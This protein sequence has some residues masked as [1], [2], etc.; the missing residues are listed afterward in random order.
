MRPLGMK[1][2]E[3]WEFAGM[4]T[5]VRAY[6]TNARRFLRGWSY[7]EVYGSSEDR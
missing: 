7:R 5:H 3:P 4:L 1:N 2:L 6:L